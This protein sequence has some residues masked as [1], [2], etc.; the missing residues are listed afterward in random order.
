[1]LYYKTIK[2]P[3]SKEWTIFIHGAGGSSKVWFKQ[4]RAF[5]EN[6]NVLMLDLRGH[7]KSK[8]IKSPSNYSFEMIDEDV[9]EVVTQQDRAS[10]FYW[11]FF[12]VYCH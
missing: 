2:H 5:S 12:R 9:V 4:I 10:P 11:C 3:T 8:N 1:M 7:G 6:F